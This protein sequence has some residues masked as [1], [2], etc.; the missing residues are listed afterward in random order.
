[1]LALKEQFT[2]SNSNSEEETRL[3]MFHRAFFN[4][5]IDKT[6]TQAL[7]HIQHCTSLEC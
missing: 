7:F 3:S 5:I 1:M 6:P 2:G 4:S